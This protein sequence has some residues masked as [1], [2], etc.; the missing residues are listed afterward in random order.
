MKTVQLEMKKCPACGQLMLPTADKTGWFCPYCPEPAPAAPGRREA[1]PERFEGSCAAAPSPEG[2]SEASPRLASPAGRAAP[3]TGAGGTRSSPSPRPEPREARSVAPEG[4]LPASWAGSPAGIDPMDEPE[5]AAS[6]LIGKLL[7]G[8]Y[9]LESVLGQGAMGAVY[10]AVQVAL[11]K[12]YA[13]KVLLPSLTHDRQFEAR[14]KQ[15][16]QIA[17]SL[18]H[19]GL[20]EVFDYGVEGGLAY[21]VMEFLEG[22]TLSEAL[23]DRVALDPEEAV[24][25]VAAAADALGVAHDRGV[26]HRDLKPA[27]LFLARDS[28]GRE[29]I[30]VLDFGLS[31]AVASVLADKPP[32]TVNGAICGTPAYMSPEQAKGKSVD[33]RSDIYSLAVVLFRTLTGKVPFDAAESLV[34]L[35]MHIDHQPPA[36]DKCRPGIHVPAA[37]EAA[38]YRALAKRPEDRFRS[39]AEFAAALRGSVAGRP[40]GL[41]DPAMEVPAAAPPWEPSPLPLGPASAQPAR[42]RAAAP[43]G[44][45]ASSSGGRVVPS[46]PPPPRAHA[47]GGG[48]APLAPESMV[49]APG[50]TPA[51]APAGAPPV[52]RERSLF[53]AAGAAIGVIALVAIGLLLADPWHVVPGKDG[54]GVS[55]PSIR[56][57]TTP[58]PTPSPTPPDFVDQP[59]IEDGPMTPSKYVKMTEPPPPPPPTPTPKPA[60]TA[61]PAPVPKPPIAPIPTPGKAR[62]VLTS[63]VAGRVVATAGAQRVELITNSPHLFE[64]TAGKLSVSFTLLDAPGRC[65][66]VLE[67]PE[68]QQRSLVFGPEVESIAQLGGSEGRKKLECR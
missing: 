31:K 5:F 25:I 45:P 15:E 38:L 35:Y 2:R 47:P 21:Y 22:Q 63:K 51:A 58:A 53:I 11:N 20:V 52:P 61:K 46:R 6:D 60:P 8:R 59:P 49:L 7:G 41:F 32:M 68:A 1:G 12:P 9:R 65:A 16:A 62:L 44:E 64:V 34:V 50:A 55:P 19:P 57:E 28:A 3:S 66:V 14:F 10:K 54:G 36:L 48:I 29:R 24:G 23:R 33:G 40:P 42:G 37:L 39:M 27:N 30:K 67:I 4:S 17:A 43:L 56:P 13:I 18:R 26:V